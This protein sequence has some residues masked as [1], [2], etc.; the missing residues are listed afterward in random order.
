MASRKDYYDILGIRRGATPEEIEKAFQKLTRTYQFIP[1]PGNKTAATCFKE[2]SEAYEILSDKEKRE[3]Y[4]RSGEELTSPP[5]AWDDDAEEE[6]EEGL[7]FEGFEDAL[8]QYLGT[9]EFSGIPTP[10]RGK[11]VHFSLEISFDEAMR[12]ESKVI[13][14]GREIPCSPCSGTGNDPAG[15]R[16][17]CD[18]CGGAGQVQIG[19]P[20]AAFAEMCPRCQGQGKIPRQPC[21]KCLGKG[22]LIEKDRVRLHV[23]P[24]ASDKCRIFS[25][26]RG[27]GGR[28]GGGSGDLITTIKVAPHPFFQRRGDNLY[29][30]VPL[31]VWEAALGAEIEIPTLEGMSRVTIPS[32]V[33]DGQPLRLSQR[34][35][36]FFYGGG[37]GDL[38]LAVKIIIPHHLGDR[39]K[40][41]LGELQ[42]LNPQNPRE[43]CP[44]R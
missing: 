32:G 29:V 42:R 14:V 37:R 15:P 39:S 1:N 16:K 30:T 8:D 13:E 43:D 34:G 5:S 18:R 20:P 10:Q 27:Q 12:G 23:P 44:W 31:S 21:G 7:H 25:N 38:V 3:K 11:D 40:E 2:I 22:R 17:I 35:A 4:D 28:N 19:L 36:P 41:I 26:G 33:Q 24:G 6:E 9:G